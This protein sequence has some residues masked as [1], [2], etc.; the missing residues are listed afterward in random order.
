MKNKVNHH[1]GGA[2]WGVV[3]FAVRARNGFLRHAYID[4]DVD[5]DVVSDLA[6]PC[7]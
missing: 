7:G 2:K 3:S 4:V 1:G 5:V 6:F